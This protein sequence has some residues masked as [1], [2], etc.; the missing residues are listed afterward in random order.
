VVEILIKG[1]TCLILYHCVS[2]KIKNG[3]LAEYANYLIERR[4]NSLLK[5]KTAADNK[6]NDDGIE[7]EGDIER[8]GAQLEEGPSRYA[9]VS[10][11]NI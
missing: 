2:C 5:T 10:K 4:I 8:D 6:D 7:E 1:T 3:S 11:Q 9:T